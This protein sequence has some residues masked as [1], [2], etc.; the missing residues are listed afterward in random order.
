[1]TYDQKKSEVDK[2]FNYWFSRHLENDR[3][4]AKMLAAQQEQTEEV[5]EDYERYCIA[6]NGTGEGAYDGASC[7]VC[8]GRSY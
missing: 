8:R 3:R 6:C 1:M 7:P 2:K 5:E 4:I